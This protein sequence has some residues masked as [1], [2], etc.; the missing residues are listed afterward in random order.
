M[1]LVREFVFHADL[2]EGITIGDGPVGSRIVIPV[3]GGWIKGERLNGAVVGPGGDWAV[4]G[5]D[6]FARST[7]AASCEPT[8]ARSCMCTTTGCWN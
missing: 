1:D 5:G 3:I 7:C 6:G 2:G 4:F 8:T